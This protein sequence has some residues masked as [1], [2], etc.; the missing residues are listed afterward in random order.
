[1]L[2]I[3]S[4]FEEFGK[5]GCL[6]LCYIY[7]ALKDVATKE[8]LKND[9]FMKCAL[10]AALI[11]ARDQSTAVGE[12]CFVNNPSSLMES[13]NGQKYTITKRDIES[14]EELKQ[15]PKA[16]VRF[17]YNGKSH[18]VYV[19]YGMIVFNGLEVSNCV[20]YGKPTTAR[21]IERA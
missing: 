12:E 16:A 5:Y 1:M 8:E 4:Q 3:Q 7:S 2:K 15:V 13:V 10:A 20:R 11:T 21:I 14:L 9:T 18:F 6:A 17:D 19:E